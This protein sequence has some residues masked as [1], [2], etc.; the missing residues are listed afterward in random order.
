MQVAARDEKADSASASIY[1]LTAA[2]ASAADELPSSTAD[3][4]G[5]TPA[6]R[7]AAPRP[8][9]AMRLRLVAPQVLASDRFGSLRIASDRFRSLRIASDRSRSLQI[10]SDCS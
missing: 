4:G 1:A 3:E 10:A 6:R 9:L 2:T 5:Q 8:S 7:K